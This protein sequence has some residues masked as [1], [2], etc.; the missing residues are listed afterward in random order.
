MGTQ[1]AWFY[2]V[3]AAAIL[4]ICLYAGGKRGFLRSII[5]IAGYFLSFAAAYSISDSASPALYEKFV[6]PK[7]ISII[8][9][10]IEN[11]NVTGEVKKALGLESMG[12]TVEDEEINSLIRSSSGD[13]SGDIHSIIQQKA[14][15]ADVPQTEI[16]SKLDGIFSS[17]LVSKF[18]SGLPGNI[19]EAL[20][21]YSK[22]SS[23]AISDTLKVLTTSKADAAKFI[24]VNIIRSSILQ[25]MRL[26]IF[27]VV[28]TFAL[29]IVKMITRL[30]SGFNRI[31]I[32]G[33]VNALLGGALG[34]AQGLVIVLV[35]ALLLRV[36]IF[37]SSNEMIVINTQ[38]IDSTHLFK[39]FYYFKLLK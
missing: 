31:P 7:V 16:Q 20:T 4:L 36:F 30:F 27:V 13:L 26:L 38:T 32:A 6:Q 5:L 23:R 1:F 14:N 28:F 3:A 19:S 35:L 22:T 9:D 39:E 21:S 24:E 29:F 17:S 33:P 15:G 8:Q 25:A 18:L 10:K 34:L 2:D 37:A 12:I 11:I